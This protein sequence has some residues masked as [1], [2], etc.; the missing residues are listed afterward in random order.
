[1]GIHLGWN[2]FEGPV[3]GTQLSGH[4][5]PGF[6]S[7][8]LT[9]PVAWTGG[10]FGPEAGLACILIVGSVGFFLCFRAARQH[11]MLPRNWR[12]RTPDNTQPERANVSANL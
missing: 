8:V 4:A 9:G 2:F 12:Q 10:S 3:F 1:M 11:R 5:L 6:F 7:S